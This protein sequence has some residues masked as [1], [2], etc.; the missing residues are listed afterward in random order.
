MLDDVAAVAVA[1][2]GEDLVVDRVE[3]LAELL[4]LLVA[5][6]GQ[7][8]LDHRGHRVS[9][10]SEV[11]LDGALGRVDAGADHLARRCRRPSPVRRSRTCP[12]HSFPTQ[13]WQMPSRQPNGSS[14]PASSPAT[15]IGVRAVGLGLVVAVEEAD[16]RRPRPRSP[17]PPMHRLEALEVQAVAVAV[18]LPVLE[19]RVEHVAGA[20]EEG[21]AL[22]PVR[23]QLVEVGRAEPALLAGELQ[24]AGDSRRGAASSARSCSPKMTSSSRARGVEV[25]DVVELVA[26]VEVAQHAHDRRDRRCRR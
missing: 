8:A 11:D 2:V 18:A 20:R 3:L 14:S 22:A 25:H 1:E 26:A 4:D 17:S 23:A 19:H 21:L 16:R 12:E 13:V 7:R 5:Q 9:F 15:R 10:G 6:A 24:R